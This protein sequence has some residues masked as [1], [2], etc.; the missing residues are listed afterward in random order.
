ML[1]LD[2]DIDANCK[3]HTVINHIIS[4]N[5]YKMENSLSI[6]VSDRKSVNF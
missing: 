2:A 4:M 5:A 6:M 3:N 1:R